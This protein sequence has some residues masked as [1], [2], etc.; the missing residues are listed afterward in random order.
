MYAIRSYYE[1]LF[2]AKIS[3][4]PQHQGE[5]Y[6]EA[7][8]EMTRGLRNIICQRRRGHLQEALR[9]AQ[10]RGDRDEELRLAQALFDAVNDMREA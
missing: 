8:R 9:E 3:E 7:W 4:L 2:V 10:R 5:G 6:L 1:K